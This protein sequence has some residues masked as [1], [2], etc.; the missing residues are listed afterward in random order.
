M[1]PYTLRIRA[2]FKSYLLGFILYAN[3][4]SCFS[5]LFP[6]DPVARYSH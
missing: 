3:S 1:T 4:C 2:P 5:P 6:I